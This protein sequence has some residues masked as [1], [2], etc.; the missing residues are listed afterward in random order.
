MEQEFVVYLTKAKKID[1]QAFQ[2]NEPIRYAEWLEL[3]S[4]VHLKNFEQ[5]KLFLIN[6]LRKRFPV[7]DS[8]FLS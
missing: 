2:T 4:L 8:L 3:F 5:Q 1:A 6:A 7:Q